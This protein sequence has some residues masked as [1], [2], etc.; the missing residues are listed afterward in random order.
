MKKSLRKY[1]LVL[2]SIAVAVLTAVGLT[3]CDE[4]A[5]K[6]LDG[7][8]IENAKTIFR[9]GDEFTYGE[10][11]TVYAHYT[12]DTKVDVTSEVSITKES[13]FDMSV[14][15]NYQI[16]VS[17]GGKKEVYTIYV[18]NVEPELRKMEIDASAVKTS[19]TLGEN[20]SF[21]GISITLT[22]ETAQGEMIPTVKTSVREFSVEIK[23]ENGKVV[24][25][26][27]LNALGAYTVTIF[28]T[29]KIKD[30]YSVVVDKVD[31]SSV[32][33]A[34]NLAIIQK[35]QVVSGF[36][37]VYSTAMRPNDKNVFVLKT[38]QENNYEYLYG[39]NY[40]YV[41]ETLNEKNEKHFSIE[42]DAI[43]CVTV[44]D[45]QLVNSGTVTATMM[46]GPK[47]FLWYSN[48]TTYGVE[49]AIKALY[50]EALNSQTNGLGNADLEETVDEE[51]RE[52]SFKYTG[53]VFRS[54]SSDYYEQT[55]T[56]KLGENYN[57]EHAE[58]SQSYWENNSTNLGASPTFTTTDGKTTPNGNFTHKIDISFDQT[59]GDRTEVNPY[60]PE[61]FKIQSF[62]FMY[63]GQPL[64][65]NGTV[66]CSVA[67]GEI[68]LQIDIE[69]IMP[70]GA[71]F[72][73]FPMYFNY[74]GNT[75]DYV[76]IKGIGLN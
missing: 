18:N 36:G 11:F 57:I 51:N 29:D 56:F 26:D 20:I 32:E 13:F 59:A 10:E 70:A 34:L 7:L 17:Y 75:G 2:L 35:P 67:S 1:L 66:N 64:G 24:E 43:F 42:D 44:M 73:L 72:D 76:N 33:S 45:G 41:K 71:N 25:G 55:I 61:N 62:D 30:S 8:I 68:T 69:N 60:S 6:K 40:T 50:E 12:D 63:Q 5:G 47:I 28:A 54:N 38:I 37:E 27:A 23:H 52:Y 21:E 16:T 19:Y 65:D 14:E 49:N 22:Y 3:A 58:I 53:L 15:G 9:V 39:D 74:E 4:T 48:V 31:L 46:E